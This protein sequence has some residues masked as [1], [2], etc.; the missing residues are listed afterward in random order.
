MAAPRHQWGGH[1]A[2]ELLGERLRVLGPTWKAHERSDVA[3][4]GRACRLVHLRQVLVGDREAQAVLAGLG[5]DR[6][7][8][9]GGEVLELIDVQEE[10]AAV[11]FSGTSARLMAASCRPVTSKEPSSVD[12][13]SPMRPLLRLTSRILPSSMTR[14]Q[15]ERRYGLRPGSRARTGELTKCPTLF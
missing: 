10:V 6:G 12:A 5:E 4:D 11:G 2:A 7:E 1:L 8:R 15:V 13:S 3:E 14:A 9:F